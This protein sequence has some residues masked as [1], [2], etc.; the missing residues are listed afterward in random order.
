M[1][2]VQNMPSY[3]QIAEAHVQHLQKLVPAFDNLYSAMP[4]QQKKLA[5]QGVPR[6]CGA[7][8][9]SRAMARTRVRQQIEPG[10][11][12]HQSVSVTGACGRPLETSSRP[13]AQ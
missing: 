3:A 2:A 11:Q 10:V 6:Q 4:E 5:D 12:A 7:A 8:R 13:S 9:R 1:N